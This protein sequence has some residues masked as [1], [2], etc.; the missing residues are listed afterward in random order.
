M[1]IHFSKGRI[2]PGIRVIVYMKKNIH[3]PSLMSIDAH[4]HFTLIKMHSNERGRYFTGGIDHIP[5]KFYS[6]NK[7]A[8][9]VYK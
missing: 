5:A 6:R 7:A 8:G 2:T 1:S 3:R 9:K 4:K